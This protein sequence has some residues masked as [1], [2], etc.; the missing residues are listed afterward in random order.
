METKQLAEYLHS[1]NCAIAL[2]R[3][4]PDLECLQI[5][6]SNLVKAAIATCN[7]EQIQCFIKEKNALAM[8]ASHVIHAWVREFQRE[9][10]ISGIEW[11]SIPLGDRLIQFPACSFGLNLLKEDEKLIKEY[12]PL[13]VHAYCN[14]LRENNASVDAWCLQGY[15]DSVA[16]ASWI[17]SAD[18]IYCLSALYDL[19]EIGKTPARTLDPDK[20]SFE[21]SLLLGDR[22]KIDAVFTACP[23]GVIP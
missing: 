18:E 8:F 2:G 4:I 21:V 15:N 22:D 16:S 14:W 19:A 5:T 20:I 11:R 13:I 23:V 9:F 17:V 3:D 6:A 10:N 1:V 7:S 12:K